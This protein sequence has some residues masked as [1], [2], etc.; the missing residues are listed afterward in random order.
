MP[1]ALN[2]LNQKFG[3]L[4]VVSKLSKRGNYGQIKWECLCECGNSVVWGGGNLVYASKTTNYPLTCG[5]RKQDKRSKETYLNSKY[6]SYK[7][8]AKRRNL[9]FVLTKSQFYFLI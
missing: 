8:N 3:K 6:N 4:T 7:Q 1:R 5:C 9:I 2:L